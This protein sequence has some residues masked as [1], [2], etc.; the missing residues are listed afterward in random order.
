MD[1]FDEL[2]ELKHEFE[3]LDELDEFWDYLNELDDKI[4]KVDLLYTSDEQDESK[5]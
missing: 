1:T 5:N 3:M 4:N 2:D